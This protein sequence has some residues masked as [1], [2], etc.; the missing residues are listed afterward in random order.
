MIKTVSVIGGGSWGTALAHHLAAHS[1]AKVSL[2]VRDAVVTESINS[3]HINNKYLPGFLLDSRVRATDNLEQATR[4]SDVIVMALPSSSIG[5]VLKSIDSDV[6]AQ[7]YIVNTSKGLERGSA[8]TGLEVISSH[9]CKCNGL[10][11]LSG[12]SFAKELVSSLPTALTLASKAL[13]NKS[14][15][16]EIRS[17]FHC[18]SLRVY[19][20]SDQNGVEFGGIFKNVIAIA[21]GAIEG[22]KLGANARAALITRSLVEA[23]RLIAHL[24]ATKETLYGLSGLGDLVLTAT[25]DLSRNYK[26][27][28]FLGT[29]S[30]VEE[31]L[32]KVGQT[33]EGVW[34]AG[35]LLSLAEKYGVEL[36]I[37]EQVAA[38][39]SGETDISGALDG[40]LS[41][42]PKRE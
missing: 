7:K 39:V 14:V 10:A 15:L 20:S 30:S 32:Q 18:G 17:V 28:W 38:V 41:R 26:F 42:Q 12:P 31:S 27:G 33:V 2:W 35:E 13:Y 16:E 4:G 24:G 3:S 22:A 1:D 5:A 6:F 40:L 36:P 25:S 29:G 34:T 37:V 9:L 8:R 11:V 19:L 21:A 23:E